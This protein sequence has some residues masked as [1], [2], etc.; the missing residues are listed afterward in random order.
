MWGLGFGVQGLGFGVWDLP[1][2]IVESP[3]CVAFLQGV[4]YSPRHWNAPAPSGRR[5]AVDLCEM[6]VFVCE[7]GRKGLR[8]RLPVCPPATHRQEEG[9]RIVYRL[10]EAL[11]TLPSLGQR[12]S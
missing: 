5:F 2:V 12:S 8:Q 10:P 1:Y 4:V 3:R 7:G 11:K 9:H 6:A